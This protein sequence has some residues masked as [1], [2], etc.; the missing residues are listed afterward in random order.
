MT[1]IRPRT[2]K[3]ILLIAIG[4]LA[5][6][7]HLAPSA[8]AQEPEVPAASEGSAAAEETVKPK[9]RPKKPTPPK[10]KPIEPKA[11]ETRPAEGEKPV[12]AMPA[13]DGTL[14]E[15]AP[16]DAK[17]QWPNGA[18]S[19]SEAY[20]DWTMNCN[21]EGTQTDCVVIQSQGDRR[22]GKRQFSVEL[23]A[24][25]DGRA[26]GLILMPF[27]LQIESGVTFKLDDRTLG[28][29]APYSFCVAD[30]CLVPI[31][32]PALATDTMKT[33]QA[34]TVSAMKPD[35]KEPTVISIPLAGFAAAFARAAAFGG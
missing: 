31:S 6:S 2:L 29:G 35:A 16:S 10:V 11:V 5:A 1:P 27:G 34:L 20:G 28:K 24:P 7:A 17:V 18:R 12:T 9:P 25:K 23:R 4:T 15:P 32:L 8:W 33:A 14:L 3:A 30:G 13:T 19:V 26:E 21:R 22:T